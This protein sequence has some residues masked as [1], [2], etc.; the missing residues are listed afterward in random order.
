M[1]TPAEITAQMM[2]KDFFSQ[3]LGIEVVDIGKGYCKL[4]MQ[5]RPEMCNGFGITHGGISYSFADSALAFASNSN[6]RHAVSIETSISHIKPILPGDVLQ[7]I[8][9]QKSI[10]NRIAIYE[11]SVLRNEEVVALFKGTVFR[12]DAEW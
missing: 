5:V 10:S 8:A 9:K 6:G 1:K 11:V 12:K 3:W 4:Q 7:A 2:E